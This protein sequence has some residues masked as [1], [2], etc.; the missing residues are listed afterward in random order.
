M[1][2]VVVVLAV[3]EVAGG[4]GVAVLS[5]GAAESRIEASW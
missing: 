5:G 1:A 4:R 2:A 3:V